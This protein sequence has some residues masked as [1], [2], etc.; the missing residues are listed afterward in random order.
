VER[1]LY[2]LSGEVE[3]NK[4]KGVYE[5]ESGPGNEEPDQQETE[6]ADVEERVAEA[7]QATGT[8]AE[9]TVPMEG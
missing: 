3:V 5:A 8:I 9:D 1:G 6:N 7:A 4:I 2:T